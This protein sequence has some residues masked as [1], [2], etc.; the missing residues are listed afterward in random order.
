MTDQGAFMNLG[1]AKKG[2]ECLRLGECE[3]FLD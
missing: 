1:Y 3:F 2:K